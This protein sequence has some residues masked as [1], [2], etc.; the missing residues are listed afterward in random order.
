[1]KKFILIVFILSTSCCL[2]NAP[3]GDVITVMS[4]NVQNLFDGVDDGYEYS[5]FSV[6]KG[7]WSDDLYRKRLKLLSRII[8]LN[9]PSIVAFQEIEGAKVLSDF[10]DAYLKDYKYL[11]STADD[12]AIQIGFLSKYPITSVGHIHP[13]GE[14]KGIRTL[15]EVSFDIDGHK[16]ILINNHWKSKRGGFTEDLRLLSAKSLKKRLSELEDS[17]VVVLGDLNENYDEY[18]RIRKSYNTALMFNEVGDGLTL[19]N[20]RV[21]PGFLY[22]PW[23]KSKLPGSYIYRGEWESIDHFLLNRSLMNSDGFTYSSFRVDSRTELYDGFKILKWSNDF[24]AGYSDH[25]PIIL[26]LGLPG[27]KTTL[28]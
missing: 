17:E 23:H 24:Q 21:E 8:K 26:E 2:E 12:G 18:Q 19:T 10:R 5:E 22:T 20:G 27:I 13:G 25:L 11:T 6:S 3:K 4:W 7:L 15:L 9:N 14:S 1:M 28:E 16:I